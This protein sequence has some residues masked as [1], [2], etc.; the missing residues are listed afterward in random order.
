MFTSW[1]T[2]NWRRALHMTQPMLA[3]EDVYGLQMGLNFVV[4]E[5]KL[6]TDGVFGRA[7]AEAL[8]MAQRLLALAADGVA[9]PV[10]QR[11]I[12]LKIGNKAKQDHPLV[13]GLP[14]GQLQH[15]SGFQLGA[16]S[17][18]RSDGTYDAG[19]AQRNTAHTPAQDG[20]DPVNAIG[21]LCKTVHDAHERY[22]KISD[23]LRRW[24]LAAGVWN[25]PAYANQLAWEEGQTNIPA[26][27]RRNP[28]LDSAR[29][30]F[31]AYMD[32]CSAYIRL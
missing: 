10:T 26:N 32:S 14:G 15:E 30:T 12:A 17:P 19:V 21:V 6:T 25:A 16:Y 28:D 31:E 5:A 13:K 7:T 27:T 20:F 22:D 24:K 29:A 9:G 2:Y 18:L 3:G 8:G 1:P 11:A 4:P 23:P